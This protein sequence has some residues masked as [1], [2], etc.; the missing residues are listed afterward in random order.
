[1]LHSPPLLLQCRKGSDD[2]DKE[3]VLV[4]VDRAQPLDQLKWVESLLTFLDLPYVG[5]AF[6]QSFS[7]VTLS[8][9]GSV[10]QCDKPLD[11]RLVA[12]IR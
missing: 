6:T 11:H 8:Q 10:S 7:N 9:V 4:G 5:L 3:L 12:R 2:V 1:M